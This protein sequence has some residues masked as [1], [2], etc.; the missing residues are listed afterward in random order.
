MEGC[1]CFFFHASDFGYTPSWPKKKKKK[2]RILS[3][4]LVCVVAFVLVE[5]MS[6]GMC[7]SAVCAIHWCVLYRHTLYIVLNSLKQLVLYILKATTTEWEHRLAYVLGRKYY[8]FYTLLWLFTCLGAQSCHHFSVS[9]L[10]ERVS[11]SN[12][13]KGWRVGM[14]TTDFCHSFPVLL[15]VLLLL[16]TA[17]H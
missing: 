16:L 13:N 12:Q 7:T 2:R 6:V 17:R 4:F 5:L 15:Q 8:S 11:I 10:P 14:G 9:S 1:W 3:G